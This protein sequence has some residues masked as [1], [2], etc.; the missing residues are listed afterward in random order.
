MA[1]INLRLYG[2]QIFPN[3]TKYLAKYI[4]PEIKKEEF[5]SMYKSGNFELKQILLK[6][7]FYFNPQMKIEEGFISS[8][9]I[10]IP[11]EKENFSL[12]LEDLKC[13]ITISEMN[14]NEIE[15]LLIEEKTKI[16]NEFINYAV[17]K[18]QKK[19]GPSFLDNLIKNVVEKIINGLTID[20]KKLE[21]KIKAKNRDNIYFVILID[22]ANYLIDRGIILNNINI[23]YQEGDNIINIIDKFNISITLKSPE[24]ND[25]ENQINMEISES[26]LKINKKIFLELSNILD[27]LDET[28]YLKIY[29]KYK[30]LIF[31]HKPK[32]KENDKKDFKSL[33]LFAIKTVIKLQKYVG[34]NKSNI[35]DLPNF[36]QIKII[37]KYLE[38]NSKIDEILL[39][40]D[41][42]AFKATKKSVE[43]KILDSKNSNVLAN[44]FSFFF[45]SKKEEKKNELTEEEKQIMEEIY[46]DENINKY[47]NH[48]IE[49]S[50]SNLN[51]IFDRIKSFLSNMSLNFEFPKLKIILQNENK[52]YDI[53]FF[54]NSLKFNFIYTNNQ[55]DLKFSIGDIGYKDDK[56]F[57]NIKNLSN[58]IEIKVD[59]NNIIDLKLGFENIEIKIN[60]L[61]GIFIFLNSIKNKKSQKIFHE[62]INIYKENKQ[63]EIQNKIIDKILNFS[64]LNNFNI[65]NIPSLSIL[66]K[67]NKIEL[68]IFNY[69]LNENSINFTIN[70]I[71]SFGIILNDLPINL[72]KKDKA[73]SSSFESPIEIALQN[74]T[75]S[76]IMKNYFEYMKEISSNNKKEII[77]NI[78]KNN[79]KLFGF[80]YI[81]YKNIDFGNIDFNEYTLKIQLKEIYLKILNEKKIV[82]NSLVFDDINLIYE[83]KEVK[84]T[85]NIFTTNIDIKSNFLK[86]FF[87]D[88]KSSIDKDGSIEEEKIHTKIEYEKAL[89]NI[90]NKFNIKGKE[91]N[92]L[93]NFD[94]ILL[95][96]NF[97]NINFYNEENNV[98]IYFVVDSWNLEFEF[99]GTNYINNNTILKCDKKS[100]LIYEILSN[101]INSEF[102]SIVFNINLQILMEIYNKLLSLINKKS[103]NN[104]LDKNKKTTN[105]L[106]TNNICCKPT[107]EYKRNS[108][109]INI[110]LRVIDLNFF[111]KKNNEKM[112]Q[113]F[114][115]NFLIKSSICEQY[116]LHTNNFNYN[117]SIQGLDFIYYDENSEK[118]NILTKRKKENNEKQI[119][120]KYNDNNY[121]I[122]TNYNE[123]NLKFD[124]FLMIYYYFNGNN[125]LKKS[126]ISI[127][128]AKDIKKSFTFNFRD[129]LFQLS[130]SFEGKENI[131]LDINNFSIIYNNMNYKFPYGNY[132]L[133][134][135]KLSSNIFHKNIER[136]L[137]KTGETYLKFD[138][139]YFE[140][141]I[142]L[143]IIIGE[144]MINLSYK[145]FVSFL[146]AYELN[147]K[148]IDSTMKNL[149]NMYSNIEMKNEMS[150]KKGE[151][152]KGNIRVLNGIITLKSINLTLID[153]SKGS[154][155]PFLNFVLENFSLNFNP[156]NS[157]TSKFHFRLSSYNYIA[158]VWEPAIEK[159]L[160][161]SNGQY[162]NNIYEINIGIDCLQ[163]NLSDMNISFTLIIFNDWLTKLEIENTLISNNT[164]NEEK[165]YIPKIINNQII[166]YTGIDLNVIHDG[167]KISCPKYQK[168]ELEDS[169]LNEIDDI[170]KPKNITLIYDKDKKFKIPLEKIITL[171]HIINEK[172]FIISENFLSENKTINISLYSPILFKNKTHLNLKIQ[173]SNKIFGVSQV[174][175]TPNSICGLPLNLIISNTSFCFFLMDSKDDNKNN[176]KSINFS[177]DNIINCQYYTQTIYFSNTSFNMKLVKS[178]GNLKTISIYSEY[179]I[180]NCLPCYVLVEYFNKKYLIE[181]C[182]QHYIMEKYLDEIFVQFTINTE[183]GSFISKKVNLLELN[184]RINEKNKSINIILT[185]KNDELG[186]KFELPCIFK[187]LEEERLFIIYSEM[188]VHNRSGLNI[189][190]D[191]K[192]N[193]N[194]LICF[195]IDENIYLIS[196]NINYQEEELK[197]RCNKYYSNEIK[198]FKLIQIANN[199]GIN[200]LDS[201][202]KNLFDIKIKKKFSYIKLMNNPNFK[203]NIISIIFSIFPMCRIFN[204]LPNKNI[205]ISD[206]KDNNKKF[207][208]IIKPLD[209][210][211]FRFFNKGIHSSLGITALNLNE[212]ENKNQVMI[213]LR[214]NIGIYT[215]VI[216][217]FIFNLDIKRNPTAGCLDV[218]ILENNINNT[219]TILENLSDETITIYQKNF[220]KKIQILSPKDVSPLKIYDF[221]AKDFIFS[222]V[223]GNIPINIG[224]IKNNRKAFKLNNK[225]TIVIQDNEIKMKITFYQTEKY[226]RANSSLININ[227][228][229]QIKTINISVIGDNESENPKLNKYIRNELLLVSINNFTINMD[230][231]QMTGLLNKNNIKT[232]IQYEKL[233]I[234]NQVSS[235]GKFACI[236]KNLDTPCFSLENELN[237]YY[238]EKIINIKYQKYIIKKLFLGIDPDFIGLFLKFVDNVFY[239]MDLAYFNISK[240]FVQNKK[241]D[242][243]RLIKKHIKGRILINAKDLVYP[244]LD[245][246]FQIVEKG[247]KSLL[248]ERFVCS[249]FYIWIAKGLVGHP[250]NMNI[251]E[252]ILNYSNGTFDQ[253][254]TWLYYEYLTKIDNELSDIGYKAIFG[255]VKK[256]ITLN[257]F[258]DSQKDKNF[259]KKKIRET[260]AFYGKFKYFR[261][262]DENEANLIRKTFYFNQE[263]M[264]DKYYPIKIIREKNNF[265]LFT[266]LAIF[267]IDLFMFAIEWNVHYFSIKNAKSNNNEV[268]ILYNQKIDNN[269]SFTFQ[270]EN[271]E[272]A[273]ELV[274]T[275]NEET[276]KNRE[277]ILGL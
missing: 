143:N 171:N 119:E 180:I 24:E 256:I 101:S 276:L 214:F 254:F 95:K 139:N 120:I 41:I 185:F 71:D 18:I 265:Y 169:S 121:E 7:S 88:E 154:Y 68:K 13:M 209:T 275:I 241:S 217:D 229:L 44:A 236:L 110:I 177:L 178:R 10:N 201:Q 65:S 92:L 196:S 255:K 96:I 165:K 225:T 74:G 205:L 164:D 273:R 64:F 36:K 51:L 17:I 132:N 4:S 6:E 264:K 15:K 131:F 45:G 26:T 238:D 133:F 228:Y 78:S 248:K 243:K 175:L 39:V 27:I 122:N 116:L 156:D 187:S 125:S 67:D 221:T 190:I 224:E 114:M 60:E 260:R 112:A 81:S 270:C 216:D 34:F 130:T 269:E 5:L 124:A 126:Y 82:E 176:N 189:T 242:P 172:L 202:G 103:D 104:K 77:N 20:I 108:L 16:I 208:A 59:K 247:L 246:V 244:K 42:N 97:N 174:E 111:K 136:K 252:S 250:E 151:T 134:F 43:K 212:S 192:N 62:K 107:K 79:D 220:D 155:Q 94:K 146:R 46:N 129:S 19:D 29:T 188:I 98:K 31:F 181:K 268:K 168:I 186:K 258:S 157:F 84:F 197:F 83:K 69:T 50:S 259:L 215:M 52:I 226:N 138:L 166:N 159:N 48:E 86:N 21:L 14:E 137:F 106:E 80:N 127:N 123:I 277:N 152:P 218:Y 153:D 105:V 200:M 222:S 145:D 118:H 38:N 231:K 207:S 54:M 1:N 206:I 266:N 274:N 72:I 35:F 56:S 100:T 109:N 203:E 227:T 22:N 93:I 12:Y 47:I 70:L 49:T 89:K 99:S 160:I 23:I 87:L 210:L 199:L 162:N 194:N 2:E 240:V 170:R 58:A 257:V 245:I 198:I 237:Y 57:F 232:K 8:L 102:D 234:Y 25:K 271:D 167:K 144:L 158:C 233:N 193:S 28:N 223:N 135:G 37:E 85:Y 219:Q 261:D 90:L 128:E 117:L 235:E 184:E 113:I 251:K 9:K 163:I 76:T 3:I 63:K 179:N 239:R 173:F 161:K 147:L 140:E 191:Y 272:I 40:E 183:F 204:L 61:I 211:N 182:S 262:Y 11:N 230:L 55:Y 75:L 53:N 249:D 91:I 263:A 267:K 141:Y 213:K 253:Y 150:N 30:K 115:N 33:W 195:S 73:I 148:L 142:S 66:T 149:Q 32:N